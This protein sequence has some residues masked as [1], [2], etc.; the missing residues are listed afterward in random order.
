MRTINK[1]IGIGA[2]VM[3]LG[4]SAGCSAPSSL[5]E[6]KE[7]VEENVNAVVDVFQGDPALSEEEQAIAFAKAYVS[8]Y[9]SIANETLEE[10]SAVEYIVP[11]IREDYEGWMGNAIRKSYQ[12]EFTYETLPEVVDARIDNLQK[13]TVEYHGATWDAYQ[14]DV[15]VKYSEE[16]LPHDMDH[17]NVVVSRLNN[18][19]TIAGITWPA[20]DDAI[21]GF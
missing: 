20:P 9:F 14:M 21:R 5:Q 17:L 12:E 1:I 16:R 11:E 4:I 15:I 8:E 10:V 19:W 6:A 2:L 7:N 3:L 13:T 18:V